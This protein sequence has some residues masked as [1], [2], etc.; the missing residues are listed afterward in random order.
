[1]CDNYVKGLSAFF[2]SLA[3]FFSRLTKCACGSKRNLEIPLHFVAPR[4]GGGRLFTWKSKREALP[5]LK[6]RTLSCVWS[7]LALAINHSNS[8]VERTF[9]Y[10]VRDPATQTSTIQVS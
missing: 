10:I 5:R 2:A 4:P 6:W 1:M 9:E 7:T 3:L 8:C